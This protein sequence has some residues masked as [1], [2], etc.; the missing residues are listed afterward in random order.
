MI[1]G[2]SLIFG[3][4]ALTKVYQ[5]TRAFAEHAKQYQ[6][7]GLT[8]QLARTRLDEALAAGDISKAVS[9]IRSIGIEALAEN[10]NWLLIHRDRPV[11]AQGIG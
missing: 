2:Y 8:M 7:M 3:A 5:Q 4:A 6:R 1:V 9:V 11:S 10:G